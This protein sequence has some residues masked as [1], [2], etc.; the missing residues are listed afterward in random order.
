M[1][2]SQTQN[3]TQ[4]NKILSK[5]VS[6][7]LPASLFALCGYLLGGCELPFGTYPLGVA[8]LAAADRNAIFV[9]AGLLFFTLG[10]FEG[11]TATVFVGIYTA[12]LLLRILVR[13][14]LNPRYSRSEG[15]KALGELVGSFFGE[16]A[17][18]R[19]C[20]AALA[21]FALSFSVLA[22]GGFL[23]YDLFGLMLSAIICPLAT[24]IFY[25]YFAARRKTRA[26]KYLSSLGLIAI[27]TAAIYSASSIKIY[28]VSLAVGGGLL[29]VLCVC[30]SRGF[31][32]G[33]LLSIALGLAYSP[34]L[35]P[36]F[37]ICAL[38]YGIFTKISTTLIS[39]CALFG[40]LAYA[41]YARGIY[42]LDGISGG[43]IF[44][45]IL[46]SVIVKLQSLDK[47]AECENTDGRVRCRVLEESELDSVRLFDMNR[48]MSA[49][50]EGF[51]NLS[52][53][54]DQMKLKFPRGAELKGICEQAFEATCAG[55][56]EY[57]KCR[58]NGYLERQ[59]LKL[60]ATLDEKGTLTVGDF[61]D[62][63]SGECGRL[64]EIIDEINYN[65]EARFGRRDCRAG[66]SDIFAENR[67]Y[68]Y[69]AFSRLISESME[70]DSEEY[71]PDLEASARL[72]E[73]LEA[74]NIGIAGVIV[75]GSRRKRLYLKGNDR[76]MLEQGCEQICRVARST[77][78]IELDQARPIF[79][80]CGANGEGSV[81]LCQ[82]ASLSVSCVTQSSAACDESFCGDSLC[83]F[84]NS[85]QRF[86]AA[87]SDGMGSGRDA[88][89][90]SELTTGFVKN[91]L[92]SGKMST[93]ILAMLNSFL[94]SRYD[95]SANECSATLDLMELDEISGRATFFKCGAA[96]TYIYRNNSLFKLRSRTMPLGI[97][98][99]P[100]ARI[101]DFK[102]DDGDVIVMMSDGVT[103]GKEDCPY[104]FDLLKQNIDTAGS[105]RTADLIM[106]YAKGNGSGDDITVA[107]MRV[108]RA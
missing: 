17:G 8:L 51:A 55:C 42:A 23:Y 59:M 60:S 6:H 19:V 41:F 96:P 90:M 9:Y 101:L 88:A 16:Q 83:A 84:E 45:C 40:S 68:G 94:H 31:L 79:S 7:V 93:E 104:L 73:P 29:A 100:D 95:S 25:G 20:A 27:L 30:R 99:E 63:L 69:K 102:L 43:V 105:A 61:D 92:A 107:I 49:M 44:A 2:R 34:A 85:E 91:M 62:A 80:R 58:Y 14:T 5:I 65:F 75:Y 39:S 4:E 28:G 67:N 89:L 33:L 77:L 50:S 71:L 37:I 82:R 18:Y 22:G 11:G 72:C 1:D 106:K 15:K 81:E 48:R 24:Y 47:K 26:Q 66:E 76:S 70:K 103:A 57:S 64:L 86:F 13:L 46:F 3:A 108:S 21:V 97:L 36:I 78:G 74:L 53:L 56:P 12:L 32:S 35:C 87:L 98:P 38:S 10:S 54:F 52:S